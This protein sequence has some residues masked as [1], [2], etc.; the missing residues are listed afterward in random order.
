MKDCLQG[1]RIACRFRIRGV[2]ELRSAG[3]ERKRSLR[4]CRLRSTLSAG[5]QVTSPAQADELIGVH[6]HSVF[7]SVPWS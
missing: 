7:T 2:P 4:G 5:R 3:E 6:S 1:P